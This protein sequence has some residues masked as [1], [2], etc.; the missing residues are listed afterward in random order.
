[1]VLNEIDSPSASQLV[2]EYDSVVLVP[3]ESGIRLGAAVP[4]KGKTDAREHF[5]CVD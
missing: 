2:H 3:A 4:A 1:M 5:P